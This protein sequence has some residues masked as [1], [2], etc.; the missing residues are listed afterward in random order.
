[1]STRNGKR[2][3]GNRGAALSMRWV[4]AGGALFVIAA[5]LVATGV[6]SGN[7]AESHAEDVD[8]T[9]HD[10]DSDQD[11]GVAGV[12]HDDHD[13]HDGH[14]HGDDVAGTDA[15]HDDHEGHDHDADTGQDD[16]A[17]HDHAADAGHDDHAGHDHDA[18]AD[19]HEGHDH[20]ADA[21]DHDDHD[22]HVDLVPLTPAEIAEFGVIV[23]TA[24]PGV[25]EQTLEVPG[26]VRPNDD[27]LAH[28]V[29]R[30]SGIVTD[31]RVGIG[32]YVRQGQVLAI[33]E[34]DESLAPFEVKTLLSGTVIGKHITLGEA[35]SRDRDTFVIADLSTVWIDLTV[36]QRD[37]ERVRVGQEVVLLRGHQEA[38]ERGT[39]SYVTPIVDERTRTATARVVLRNHEQEWRPG[40]FVTGQIRVESED[41]ALAIP[42]TAVHRVEGRSAVF[43][44]S[45]E[46]F[47]PVPVELG[48]TGRGVVEVLSGL[49]PGDRY[50][51]DGGFTLKAE[52]E[53][54][55]F[56]HGH[57]H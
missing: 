57:A 1:M 8:H 40:M 53:K 10:H 38:S 14:D 18:D 32:D 19:D 33:I 25:I 12:G 41:V 36:Y 51:S 13:D 35:A 6:R 24:G 44:E 48:R 52:L 9:G 20:D 55:S 39:I 17:G 7:A 43:L 15:G 46:G 34:S 28:I 54:G 27:R 2:G 49:H 45:P 30:F 3:V 26:E 37:L 5:T 31:V 56:G 21:D 22:D 50:V 47:A 16:H 23:D 11:A 4:L 42:T 29:P